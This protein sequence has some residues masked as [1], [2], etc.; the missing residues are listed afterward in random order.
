ML[1]KLT[2]LWHL[3]VE[4]CCSSSKNWVSETILAFIESFFQA[5]NVHDFKYPLE[6]TR[7]FWD[8]KRSHGIKGSKKWFI[9]VRTRWN[10]NTIKYRYRGVFPEI[11][12]L[13]TRWFL[14]II[15]CDI[16]F[17]LYFVYW[18]WAMK[19]WSFDHV[20]HNQIVLKLS[21]FDHRY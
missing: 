3:W 8:L 5:M 11:F 12:S 7:Y 9:I 16:C 15:T 13:Q 20:G 2:Y 1:S 18:R 14:L 4:V 17:I 6:K 21:E 19:T 10:F